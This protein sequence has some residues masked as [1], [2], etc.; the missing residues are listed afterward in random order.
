MRNKRS[1]FCSLL[2]ALQAASSSDVLW[3]LHTCRILSRLQNQSARQMRSVVPLLQAGVWWHHVAP[4]RPFLNCLRACHTMLTCNAVAHSIRFVFF[5]SFHSHLRIVSPLSF[6]D[7]SV[8]ST[9]S[10]ISARPGWLLGLSFSQTPAVTLGFKARVI[11][12]S[13]PH[14][15]C[16]ATSP[17]RR[18]LSPKRGYA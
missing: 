11:R 16:L 12:T 15:Q 8:T 1:H 17:E 2:L 5:R 3:A 6:L 7:A 18:T 4:L 10:T 14:A 13:A 9:L